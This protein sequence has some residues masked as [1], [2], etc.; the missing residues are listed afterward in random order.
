MASGCLGPS[1]GFATFGFRDG[2]VPFRYRE[3]YDIPRAVVV[4]WE[5][6][7]Y[8]FD[9]PFDPETDEYEPTYSVYQLPDEFDAHIDH[10]SWTDLAHYG[11]RIGVIS[12]ADVVFDA[13]KRASIDPEVFSRITRIDA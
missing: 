4:K 3:F 6:T 2:R 8:V 9:C 10:R 12:T 13:T 7:L 5:G 11:E 1:P